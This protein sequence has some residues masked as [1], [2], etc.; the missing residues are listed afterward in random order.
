MNGTDVGQL[1][2]LL[3]L[4]P[5]RVRSRAATNRQDLRGKESSEWRRRQIRAAVTTITDH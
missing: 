5:S 1:L 3:A 4:R 2:R